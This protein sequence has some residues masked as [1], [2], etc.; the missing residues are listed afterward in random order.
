MKVT[1]KYIYI[2]IY[3]Y[4]YI[5]REKE[6]KKERERERQRE[7]EEQNGIVYKCQG[8]HEHF[9]KHLDF[10]RNQRKPKNINTKQ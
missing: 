8:T 5:E 6:R 7:R 4:K 1:C 9:R 10:N 2:Y 3:V